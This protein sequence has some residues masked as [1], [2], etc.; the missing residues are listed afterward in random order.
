MNLVF[1]YGTFKKGFYNHYLIE[2]SDFIGTGR[3]LEPFA[4]YLDRVP[5][6]T[7]EI[8]LIQV[9]GEVYAVDYATLIDLDLLNGH[10]DLYCRERVDIILDAEATVVK[11]WLYFTT[12]TQGILAVSG[13]YEL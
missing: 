10:P 7:K 8:P 2:D 11:A 5:Y 1:I 13:E 12:R 9:R 4:L 3:T 6:V